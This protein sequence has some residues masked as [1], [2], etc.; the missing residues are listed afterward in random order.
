MTLEE[1]KTTI[2]FVRDRYYQLKLSFE[3]AERVYEFEKIND[4]PSEKYF[5]SAWE[6]FDFMLDNF[7]KI[8]NEKQ[9]KKYVIWQKQNIQRHEQH[10]ID[11][12]KDQEK[13][14]SYYTELIEFYDQKLIPEFLKEKRSINALLTLHDKPKIDFLKEEYKKYL[15][16]MKLKILTSHYR[17]NRLFAPKRLQVMLLL[18]KQECL[19]PRYSSFKIYMDEPTKAIADFLIKK[20]HH[21]PKQFEKFFKATQ[22]EYS[23][24][25]ENIKSK[26][27]GEPKG[28]VLTMNSVE[29]QQQENRIMQIILMDKEKYGC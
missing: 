1:Y 5:F 19:T 16:N 14:I 11:S 18:H 26:Y 7:Q 6:E 21:I 23:K 9:L 4:L 3:Q 15:N 12:D 2:N 28:F 27:I 20:F 17:H 29:E 8:L 22:E 10:L 25:I 24:Y 13:Y